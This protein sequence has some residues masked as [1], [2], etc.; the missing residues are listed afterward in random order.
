[1]KTFS[2]LLFALAVIGGPIVLAFFIFTAVRRQGC[3]ISVRNPGRL[4]RVPLKRFIE[5]R[6]PNESKRNYQ[7]SIRITSSMPCS[8]ELELRVK[9]VPRG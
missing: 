7:P 2:D 4:L 6:K 1:M 3:S 5:R 9:T 8:A